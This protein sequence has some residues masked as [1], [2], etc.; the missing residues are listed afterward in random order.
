MILLFVGVG[1]AVV[2]G[3]VFVYCKCKNIKKKNLQESLIS[4]PKEEETTK[5]TTIKPKIVEGKKAEPSRVKKEENAIK[6]KVE[7]E[8]KFG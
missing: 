1:L 3:G 5:G 7:I 4:E 8:P 2:L 6:R